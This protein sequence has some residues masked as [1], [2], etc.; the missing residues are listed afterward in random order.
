MQQLKSFLLNLQQSANSQLLANNNVNS[1]SELVSLNQPHLLATSQTNMHSFNLTLS[2][3]VNLP[4]LNLNRQ[5]PLATSQINNILTQHNLSH[6]PINDALNQTIN[7]NSLNQPLRSASTPIPLHITSLNSDS[8][9][10]FTPRF[11]APS[12]LATSQLAQAPSAPAPDNLMSPHQH[13]TNLNKLDNSACSL[14]N[15]G[16]KLIL[17]YS[18]REELIDTNVNIRGQTVKGSEKIMMG[19]D[20]ERL[21]IIK[22]T[23][24]SYVTGDEDTKIAFWRSTIKAMNADLKLI[25]GRRV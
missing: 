5:Q 15:Y 18:D 22:D 17:Y 11:P 19:L 25:Y 8:F 9:A 20:P 1:S 6:Q 4:S 13:A 7:Q 14:R 21:A 3:L 16:V 10:K 2:Q 24:L 23:L 12:Q